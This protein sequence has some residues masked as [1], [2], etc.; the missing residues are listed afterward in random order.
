MSYRF[1]HTSPD[2]PGTVPCVRDR[3]VPTGLVV[4]ADGCCEPNPGCG[5]WGFVVYRDGVEIHS[6]KGG[7]NRTTNQQMELTAALEA[8]RWLAMHNVEGPVRLFSDSMY[9][10]NGCNSWRLDWKAR[11]WKRKGKDPSIANLDLWQNLDAILA[12]VPI[13]LEWC[14][15][16]VGIIGNERADELSQIG[17]DKALHHR[18]PGDVSPVT[19]RSVT[20]H[21]TSR[22]V[23]RDAELER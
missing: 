13:K 19:L 12:A 11:G 2:R 9:T 16:H 8:L 3:T 14:K 10:V 23:T 21:V 18:V 22:P 20:R 15:G 1:L 5:G 4:Y 7:S 6:A 17:R